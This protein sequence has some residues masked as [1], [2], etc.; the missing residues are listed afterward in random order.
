[1]RCL[2]AAHNGKTTTNQL[3]LLNYYFNCKHW[4]C[5]S[6]TTNIKCNNL[7]SERLV[8]A[9]ESTDRWNEEES[10]LAEVYTGYTYTHY[11]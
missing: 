9:M 6:N 5:D 11:L 1:M 10:F 3:W 7:R 2:G 4:S 8:I